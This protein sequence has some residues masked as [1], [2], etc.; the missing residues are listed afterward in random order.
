MLALQ[1]LETV[2]AALLP[3]AAGRIVPPPDRLVSCR[4]AFCA[5]RSSCTRRTTS[6]VAAHKIR[7]TRASRDWRLRRPRPRWSRGPRASYLA[8]SG[9]LK[10]LNRLFCLVEWRGRGVRGSLWGPTP[11]GS[12]EA[13]SC[14]SGSTQNE[15]RMHTLTHLLDGVQPRRADGRAQLVGPRPASRYNALPHVGPSAR[16]VGP[17]TRPRSA[18][19]RHPRASFRSRRTGCE[20]SSRATRDLLAVRHARAVAAARFSHV[21]HELRRLSAPSSSPSCK[22]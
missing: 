13:P 19:P 5:R 7:L 21:A 8:A 1:I 20:R 16:R 6:A 4:D 17:A 15:G 11:P 14:T 18:G 2:Q 9:R 12:N 10:D 22:S 3:G